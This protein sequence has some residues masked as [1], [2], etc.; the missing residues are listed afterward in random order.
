[1][2]MATIIAIH[3]PNFFP[4]L[5]FF[6]KLVRC[7]KFIFLDDVQ[8]PKT[9]GGWSNRVKVIASGNPKWITAP[10]DRDYHGFRELRETRF[11]N[12]QD[13]RSKM[14]CT[15]TMSYRKASYFDETIELIKPL[16]LNRD[17]M[18]A[19][20]NMHAILEIAQALSINTQKCTCS[21]YLNHSGKSNELLVSLVKNIGGNTYMYGGG[22]EGYQE[23]RVFDQSSISLLCQD[24]CS[25]PYPQHG[26]SKFIPGLSVIDLLMNIG[27]ERATALLHL[28]ENLLHE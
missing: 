16:I 9:G 11:K 23:Q 8:I 2:T 24:F 26:V 17:D 27:R 18:L 25:H 10:I 12:N 5:G 6:D 3:Q 21:S 20:Y 19:S 7:D 1:M 28:N 4:W 22:A 14:L 13:W 15:I